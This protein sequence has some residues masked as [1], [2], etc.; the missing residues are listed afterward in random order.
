MTGHVA[1]SRSV[2]TWTQRWGVGKVV[3]RAMPV[4]HH[5]SWKTGREAG[6]ALHLGTSIAFNAVES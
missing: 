6:T 5:H 1:Y 3:L 4:V 2:C